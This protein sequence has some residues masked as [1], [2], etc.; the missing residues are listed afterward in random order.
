MKSIK[1]TLK[2]IMWLC[3]PFWK[4]GKI[5]VGLALVVLAF[6]APIDDLIYVYYPEIIIDFIARGE[7]FS[8]M[9][10]VALVISGAGFIYNIIPKVC[11]RYFE[12]KKAQ[13]ELE[14]K[15][16]LYEKTLEIDYKYVDD[17][18]YY[19]N[20]AW[21][22]NE[23]LNQC[24]RAFDFCKNL[25][26]NLLGATVLMSVILSVGPW[27]MFIEIMQLVLHNILLARTN[28][29]DVAQKNELVPI[30]RRFSYFH[31][32]FYMKEYA[33][34]LKTSP[35]SNMILSK[36]NIVGKAKV[37][38]A[39]KYA[40][41]NAII[42]IAHELIFF[43][44][45]FTIIIYLVYN[46]IH[47]NIL[48]VGL[49]MTMILAFYRIDSKLY[50]LLNILQDANN[51]SLNAER[52]RAFFDIKP[53]IECNREVKSME[54]E[55]EFSIDVKAASFKYPNSEFGLQNIN[56]TITPGEKIAVVGENGAGKSTF[57][58]LLLRLY[59]LDDG[60]ILINGK[61]IREYN[62]RNLRNQIGVAFQN[63]NVYAM[64]FAEN[65]E[66]YRELS[67]EMLQNLIN[68]YE[69]NNIL[70][71]SA[72]SY[73][74]ELTK[75][76]DKDGI[77]LSGGEA[78]KVAIARVMVGKFGLLLLDEPSAALDPLA[79]AQMGSYILSAANTTTTI[80]VSHRLSTVRNA[81]RIIL[82]DK[83]QIVEIG[84]HDELMRLQGKYYEMF[85]EQSKNYV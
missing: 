22:L 58:K 65:I 45:E 75:E 16:T 34:D 42:N 8:Y 30:E 37:E 35:L 85:T 50:S 40:L 60:E 72:A 20:Y 80:I 28:K 71:K 67:E 2:N 69:L 64:S 59:D 29:L 82:F 13:I 47:G 38:V 56:L 73:N 57:I 66:L 36:F 70:D 74:A 83:G 26:K 39:G 21:A 14:I 51:I 48:E 7:S 84:N 68:K 41:K 76:F 27:I 11:S 19:D 63:P 32:V 31:R 1:S 44:T 3:K 78:Q 79:E 33:A 24:N 43:L 18:E 52:I 49:Y 5:Y 15:R 9:C 54:F 4:Y 61:S 23:Y 6:L 12:R 10:V 25:L 46:I 77:I 17:P 62:V 53:E 81:D 55:G